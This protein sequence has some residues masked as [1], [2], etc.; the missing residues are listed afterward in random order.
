[1]VKIT[2]TGKR[3][4]VYDLHIAENHNFMA[5]DILVHNCTEIIEPNY[6]DKEV[7]VCLAEGTNVLTEQGYFPIEECDGK[8]VYVP[9]NSD[10]DYTPNS[11]FIEAKLIDNGKRDVYGVSLSGCNYIQATDNHKFLVRLSRNKDS[12]KEELEWKELKDLKIGDKIKRIDLDI[13]NDFKIEP[14]Y[15]ALSV[16]WII[17]DGWYN[18]KVCGVCFSE[19]EK[20]AKEIVL[21]EFKKI[22]EVSPLH[23]LGHNKKFPSAYFDKNKVYNWSSERKSFVSHFSETYGVQPA[24]SLQKTLPKKWKDF[25]LNTKANIL[26]GLFSADGTVQ[27]FSNNLSVQLS[28]SSKELLNDVS[29]ALSEFGIHSKIKWNTI[30]NRNDQGVLYIHGSYSIQKFINKISFLLTP[31]KKDKLL[32]SFELNDIDRSR[33]YYEIK[34]IDHIGEKQ[35]YDLY[36][37]G[38]H[39]FIAE[40]LI[41]HN[42]NLGSIVISRHLKDGKIDKVKLRKNVDLA[43]RYLDKV[44]DRNFY[45]VPEAKASNNKWRPVG[46]GMM[47]L[48]ELFFKLN[49]PF[50]SEEAVKLSEEIAEE[51]YYQALKTSN[52]LAKEFGPHK[53]FEHTHAAH[54]RLQFDLAGYPND[55]KRWVELKE[56]IKQTGLRNSL[57]IAIA[58]NATIGSIVG[59]T[60]CIEPQLTNLFKRE[61]L[62]NEFVVINRHLVDRLKELD[63]WNEQTRGILRK[64]NGSIQNMTLPEG[65]G[66]KDELEHIKK[67]YKT[68]WE[69]SQKWLIDHAAARGKY[70]DQSQSLN[71]FQS[72]PEIG[73]LSSMYMYVWKKNLKT[74]YYLRSRPKSNINKV[75]GSDQ[76]PNPKADLVIAAPE[77]PEICEACV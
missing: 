40:D 33:K 64:D 60:E 34:S 24:K 59:T 62:T 14:D 7:A 31:E 71:L 39:H 32:N 48:A 47:G 30:K 46:L 16:G 72:T 37:E 38:A 3:T 68:V 58:P 76:T 11:R 4:P 6:T 70:I 21:N 45:P 42:C 9:Y 12:K 52:E 8:N 28:S 77:N 17:G 75:E 65:D 56:E 27:F 49:I 35:V 23:K 67:V 44:I 26:S 57:L 69:M 74:T 66:R 25:S 36:V 55:A 63:L 22:Y 43:V 29:L 10:E 2:R 51:I 19:K 50:E 18:E 13:N 15:S 61:T 53:G 54:G 41:T 20:Y 73:K 5:N 1:M